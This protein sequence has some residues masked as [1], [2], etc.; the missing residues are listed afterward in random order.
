MSTDELFERADE[1]LAAGDAEGA[2]RLYAAAW[3]SLRGSADLW[4]QGRAAAGRGRAAHARGEI[5]TAADWF[6]TDLALTR[7]LA[8]LEPDARADLTASL[9]NVGNAAL[10]AG[11]LPRARQ[12]FSEALDLAR[13]LVAEDPD[14]SPELASALSDAGRLAQTSGELDVAAAHFEE[15]VGLCRV[16]PDDARSLSVALNQFAGCARARGDLPAA[17]RAW[18]ESAALLRELD[19]LEALL[20]L[21]ATLWHLSTVSSPRRRMELLEE[22]LGLIAP[23]IESGVRPRDFGRLWD[24]AR[25]ARADLSLDPRRSR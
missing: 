25:E 8:A 22:L 19:G 24:A 23:H 21:G 5:D 1:D 13:V 2:E 14:W 4:R 15:A 17:R 11:D 6:A 7:A 9:A 10:A 20:S 3:A 12:A 18:D 16:T